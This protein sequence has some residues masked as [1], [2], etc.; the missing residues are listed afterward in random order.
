MKAISLILALVFS[1]ACRAQINPEKG[2]IITDRQDTIR[3]MVDFRT[4]AVN[5]TQCRFCPEGETEYKTYAPGEIEGYTFT[6]KNKMYESRNFDNE[7][8]VFA[9]CLVKGRISLF[10]IVRDATVYYF[11][12]EDGKAVRY[13]QNNDQTDEEQ[14]KYAQGLFRLTSRSQ[15]ASKEIQVG[16]M[17]ESRLIKLAKDYLADVYGQE[18]GHIAFEYDK[19]ADKNKVHPTV[20]LGGGY[21]WIPEGYVLDSK[22][23]GPTFTMGVGLDFEHKRQGK[24]RMYQASLAYT[25]IKTQDKKCGTINCISFALGPQFRFGPDDSPRFTARIG[26]SPNVLITKNCHPDHDIFFD[27][28]FLTFYGGIGYEIPFGKNALTINLDYKALE[29]AKGGIATLSAGIRF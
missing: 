15:R 10:K 16:M 27:F 14:M 13:E 17:T 4:N 1:I 28:N 3:G 12:D 20:F 2:Y 22:V 24:G 23:N 19:R 26:Y 11:E 5:T 6:E 9:E 7:G 18:S 29:I 8:M 25:N 21:T